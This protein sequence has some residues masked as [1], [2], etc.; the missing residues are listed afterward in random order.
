MGQQVN[1][2]GP[3]DFYT[4]Q[5]TGFVRE[6]GVGSSVVLNLFF[7]SVP[8]GALM[9]TIAPFAFPGANLVLIVIVSFALCVAPMMLYAMLGSIMPRS[10]GDYVFISR[11]INPVIGFAANFNI[12]AW[13]LLASALLVSLIAPFGL[14]AALSSIGI[15]TGNHS[16]VD[17]ATAV[18]SKNWEFGAGAV[19]IVAAALLMS[20]PSRIWT[21]IFTV[22]FVLAY[23]SVPVSIVLL[24]IHG[25]SD[26]EASLKSFGTS[27]GA[28]LSAASKA[29]YGL[30]PSFNFGNVLEATPLGYFF[31]AYAYAGVYVAG[32]LRSPARNLMRAAWWALGIGLVMM[33]LLMGLAERVFGDDFLGGATYLSTNDPTHYPLPSAPFFY[34]F[35]SMLTRNSIVIAVLGFSFVMSLFAALLP[36]W[37]AAT[38]SLFAWSFDRIIPDKVSEVSDRTHSP[39]IANAVV[40][41]VTLILL[42]LI[43]YGPSQFLV[44]AFTAGAAEIL[45]YLVLCVAGVWLPWRRRVLYTGSYIDKTVLGLPLIALL[46]VASFIAYALFLQSLLT[47]ATLGA[48]AKPGIVAMIVIAILPFA[49]YAVSYFVNKQRGVDLALAGASLP[50]E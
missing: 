10:G 12:T 15:I 41:V 46:A 38:R 40:L 50:P 19:A 24:L 4:R 26:F 30:N 47:N 32:E 36:S 20:L 44:L 28:V 5:A 37:L 49:I 27:Y 48:N 11:I 13:Y 2:T 25:R 33:L 9:A 34:F 3:K 23:L 14:S 31:F 22:I 18:S 42:A 35:V 45:T 39:L 8:Y 29:G 6:I 43:V 7:M 17:A 1:L 21:R 16:M